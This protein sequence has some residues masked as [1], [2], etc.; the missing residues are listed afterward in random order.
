[1]YIQKTR[2]LLNL[3][4]H[5]VLAMRHQFIHSLSFFA[6][7]SLALVASGFALV[8]MLAC[9]GAGPLSACRYHSQ[10]GTC[11]LFDERKRE[12]YFLSGL[13]FAIAGLTLAA[14][15]RSQWRTTRR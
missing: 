11:R 12:N 4:G 6:L 13:S 2:R 10:D 8:L 1:M 15:A 3:I 9:A 14:S 5:E 7:A